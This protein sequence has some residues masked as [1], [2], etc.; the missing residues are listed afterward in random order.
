MN[1]AVWLLLCGALTSGA[2]GP[3]ASARLSAPGSLPAVSPNQ[4]PG[5]GPGYLAPA[6]PAVMQFPP[7]AP[8]GQ[9]TGCYPSGPFDRPCYIPACPGRT[10]SAL[11]VSAEYLLWWIKSA[12]VPNALVTSSG[13]PGPFGT[14]S[15]TVLFGNHDAGFG[16][17]S[18]GR[19]S[20]GYQ[21]D[22]GL[23]VELSGFLLDQRGH[24]FTAASNGGGSPLL[25]V[26]FVDPFNG[27]ARATIIP[28]PGAQQGGIAS[29]LHSHL[30]GAESNLTALLHQDDNWSLTAL[31]G[32]RYVDL[33][34][35]LALNTA[36]T[37]LA[38][39]GL[40]NGTV[41]APGSTLTTR[42][43]F[44]TR[45]EFYGGQAGL[46]G[47]WYLG[48]FFL[49]ARGQVAL[50]DTHQVVNVGGLST[51]SL[52]NRVVAT[53]PGGLL[54][55]SSNGGRFNRDEFAVIP[56]ARA[57]LGY[58]LTRQISV[59]AGY[60]FLYWSSVARPGDQ[61]D[62]RLNTNLAPILSDGTRT[63]PAVPAPLLRST[64]FF[65]QGVNFGISFRY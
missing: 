30:W 62:R 4:I 35:G 24:S 3:P 47:T 41:A 26:P 33:R 60:N 13:S 39:P 23:G 50:G 44:S 10:G 37:L 11:W 55:V 54:A 34:E 48:R 45:N 28:A 31:A 8:D 64:D 53:A 52:Q 2:D 65:A 18:G 20:A 61:F 15:T 43:S 63:G 14:S 56:E 49:N 32:F 25:A 6:P 17:F 12:P 9:A 38:V 51:L 59:F 19:L 1:T 42:D 22:G 21:F 57:S 16:P 46:S 36:S 58:Q 27:L 29:D 40:L 7:A 5:S